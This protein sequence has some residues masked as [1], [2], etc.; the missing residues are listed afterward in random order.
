MGS[1]YIFFILN[2]HNCFKD[3]KTLSKIVK[4]QVTM[5]CVAKTCLSGSTLLS[6]SEEITRQRKPLW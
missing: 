1:I 2:S 5:T 6:Q 4:G 3:N